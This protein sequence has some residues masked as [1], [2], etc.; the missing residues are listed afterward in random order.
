MFMQALLQGFWTLFYLN[1][2]GGLYTK[3]WIF[4]LFAGRPTSMKA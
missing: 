3:S 2:R 1:G 4:H